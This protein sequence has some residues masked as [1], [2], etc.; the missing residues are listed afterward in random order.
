M[1]VLI[2]FLLMCGEGIIERSRGSSGSASTAILRRHGE[3]VC[4]VRRSRTMDLAGEGDLRGLRY[5]SSHRSEIGSTDD[6]ESA[7]VPAIT[8]KQNRDL[9]Q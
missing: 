7:E 1:V 3:L 8:T 2:T 6:P 9:Y 5:T 4:S